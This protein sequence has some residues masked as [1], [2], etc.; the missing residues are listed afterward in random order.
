MISTMTKRCWLVVGVALTSAK[1]S[2]VDGLAGAWAGN[3]PRRSDAML[4]LLL[5]YFALYFAESN[6]TKFKRG[7]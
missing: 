6:A 5:L 2:L 4:A 3:P 7:W 1:R